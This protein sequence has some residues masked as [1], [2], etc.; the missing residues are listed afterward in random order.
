[1]IYNDFLLVAKLQVVMTKE[2]NGKK[3]IR[4]TSLKYA[5]DKYVSCKILHF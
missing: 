1:M 2:N 4:M 3:R 5:Y